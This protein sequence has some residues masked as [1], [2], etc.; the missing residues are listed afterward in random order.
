MYDKGILRLDENQD[1][2]SLSAITIIRNNLAEDR[3]M[4]S[5]YTL[6][7]AIEHVGSELQSISPQTK[8]RLLNIMENALAHNLYYDNNKA[9]QIQKQALENIS[10]TRGMMQSGE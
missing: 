10:L 2:Q 3:N 9:I 4:S 7:S 1:A 5:V 6:H 8:L